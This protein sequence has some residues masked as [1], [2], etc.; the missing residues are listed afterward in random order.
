MDMKRLVLQLVYLQVQLKWITSKN[1]LTPSIF[2]GM[3]ASTDSVI[4][5]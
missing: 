3:S 1:N 5:S 4:E 2:I